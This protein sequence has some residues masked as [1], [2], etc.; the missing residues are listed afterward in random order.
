M[1]R[2]KLRKLSAFQKTQTNELEVLKWLL[3]DSE[4]F[5]TFKKPLRYT[6]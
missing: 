2:D 1:R 5:K 3:I 4:D 6:I